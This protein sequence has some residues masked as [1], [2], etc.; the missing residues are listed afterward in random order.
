MAL[1]WGVNPL[2]LVMIVPVAASK[3]DVMV[4]ELVVNGHWSMPDAVS[5]CSSSAE[6]VVDFDPVP[7]F[8]IVS[9]GG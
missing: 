6:T 1:T 2:L 3:D 5:S 8:D 4:V 7:S 9:L